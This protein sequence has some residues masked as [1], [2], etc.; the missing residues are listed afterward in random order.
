MNR[1]QRKSKRP[2]QPGTV[3]GM[4]SFEMIEDILVCLANDNENTLERLSE[5][6]G[7][8]KQ[9]KVIEMVFLLSEH[10]SQDNSTKY[11]AV[12]LLDRFLILHVEELYKSSAKGLN[13]MEVK[14]WDS[15]KAE[16]CDMFLLH[17]AS[18]IQITSKLHFHY[19]IINNHMILQFL[20][21][22]GYSYKKEDIVRSE[23]RVL[24][25]LHFSINIHSPFTYIEMLLEVL[26]Y[27]GSSL[28]MVDVQD[29]CVKVLDLVYLLRTPMYEAVLKAS[30]DLST[31]TSL[32][33]SKFLPVKEDQM[34]LAT[35]V[36]SAST[37]IINRDLW[38]EVLKHLSN[39]TGI[40]VS[41]V[42]DM[43]SAILK[44]CVGKT[45]LSN[46]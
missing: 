22:A 3:F 24:T 44:H 23:L 45:A 42:F 18:C 38:N 15:I 31:P 21:S 39:I 33:R 12:E 30:V 6:A 28:K 8:F 14:T 17:L 41:S 5:H 46:S 16:I 19:N 36:I 26:G 4:A 40:T 32:Q 13:S 29:M 7:S 43:C 37:F 34:L 27:N 1:L 25:T 9:P 10:W 2:S 11:Q 20:R 35:G